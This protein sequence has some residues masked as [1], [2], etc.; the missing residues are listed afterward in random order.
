MT[1]Y[2]RGSYHKKWQL[3]WRHAGL[4]K[5]NIPAHRHLDCH[6]LRLEPRIYTSI[7]IWYAWMCNLNIILQ[8]IQLCLYI[9]KKGHW[10]TRKWNVQL[11][12]IFHRALG[13]PR[14]RK[15]I[16]QV[17]RI[18]KPHTRKRNFWIICHRKKLIWPNQA[19]WP[20]F[21]NWAQKKGLQASEKLYP[22]RLRLLTPKSTTYN[23]KINFN[24]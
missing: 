7:I 4:I 20:P 23:I 2:I 11:S 19:I 16:F 6:F 15:I 9:W 5:R 1:S 8:F 17:S 24:K 22:V 21:W 3:K 18:W 12:A 10:K 14:V 13:A